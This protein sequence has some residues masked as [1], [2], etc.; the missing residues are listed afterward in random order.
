MLEPRHTYQD[1][2]LIERRVPD[3]AEGV[4]HVFDGAGKVLEDEPFTDAEV[5]AAVEPDP[6][7]MLLAVFAAFGKSAARQIA[8]KY[9]DFQ[10]AL[11]RGNWPVARAAVDDALTAGDLTQAKYDTMQSL[12][13]QYGIPGA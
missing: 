10:I 11:D 8:G 5:A 12:F 9:P 6:G 1:S 4:W 3:V 13:T 2:R 7:G